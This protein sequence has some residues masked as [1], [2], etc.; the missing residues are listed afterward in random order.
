MMNDAKVV[1]DDVHGGAGQVPKDYDITSVLSGPGGTAASMSG[2]VKWR[3]SRL[4]TW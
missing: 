4:K 3:D 1:Y 2:K